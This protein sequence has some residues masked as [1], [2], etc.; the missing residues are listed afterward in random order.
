MTLA[1][2]CLLSLI[3]FGCLT[4][5]AQPFNTARLSLIGVGSVD[6]F[7]NSIDEINNGITITSANTIGITISDLAAAGAPGALSGFEI[8]F[9][10]LNGVANSLE[11]VNGNLM[12]LNTVALTSSNGLGLAAASTFY[13]PIELT[14]IN[15]LLTESTVVPCDWNTHQINIQFEIGTANCTGKLSDVPSDQYTVEVEYTLEPVF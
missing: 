13:G 6:V 10:T 7:V 2:F 15:Q 12:D 9:R 11:G 4:G 3:V 5:N 8:Y 14:S 1:R